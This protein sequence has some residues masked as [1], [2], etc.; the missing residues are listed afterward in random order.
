MSILV[1]IDVNF[2]ASCVYHR[3]MNYKNQ[4]NK[5]FNFNICI[6]L[7]LALALLPIISA[8][9]VADKPTF[10]EQIKAFFSESFS[11]VG[12]DRHCSTYEDREWIV[13]PSSSFTANADD[14]CSSG[15]GLFDVFVDNY[16]ARFE[17]KN[18]VEFLCGSQNQ[19]C[20]VQLYCCPQGECSSNSDC[21]SGYTCES[22]TA[23]D[24]YIPLIDL[25]GN[26]INSYR[27]CEAIQGCTGTPITC[28]RE[29]SGNC[30]DRTYDCDYSTY[31]NCP[32]SYPYTSQSSCQADLPSGNGDNGDGNGDDGN[33]DDGNGDDGNGDDGNGDDGNG[34]GISQEVSSLS[35]LEISK[36]LVK[37]KGKLTIEGR[38][39]N[40]LDKSQKYLLEVGI[41]PTKV[42]DDWG[43]KYDPT[44]KRG[45]WKWWLLA[46]L[47][48]V[49]ETSPETQCCEG[50]ENIKDYWVTLEPNEEYDF[51]F[52]VNAPYSEIP[53]R[54]GNTDYWVGTGDYV[55]YAYLTTDCKKNNGIFQDFSTTRIEIS[56][57][58]YESMNSLTSKEWKNAVDFEDWDSIISSMCT[59][60][61][62]CSQREGYEIECKKSQDIWNTN[63]KA[64]GDNCGEFI[65]RMS[66]FLGWGLL[67]EKFADVGCGAVGWLTEWKEDIPN[68]TCR[69]SKGGEIC[70]LV[71]QLALFN[72]TGDTC[73]DGIII[74]I[75]TLLLF[76]IIFSK[77]SYS[78]Q[79][80]N[81]PIKL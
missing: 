50:Q 25:S 77:L 10:F 47:F 27:Y 70:E 46:S 11:I 7:I 1:W 2:I 34:N 35:N 16:V 60:G 59:S 80:I 44:S 5:K 74:G 30:V 45:S 26:P 51:S 8:Q 28:W 62:Q 6:I 65:S 48:A 68:G 67:P 43:F 78:V 52:E 9:V 32:S 64:V 41:I 53:D 36:T 66:G 40:G 14:Y 76:V 37:Q 33:G 58:E 49:V 57:E 31:P 71:S 81:Y 19:R 12:E 55:V 22:K 13:Q 4:R 69:A 56:A 29:E 63:T 61:S 72:I 75:G 18:R 24:P 42:A 17:M 21:N 39:E 54:C 73:T 3:K 20:I 79:E 15:Y 38:I 23:T